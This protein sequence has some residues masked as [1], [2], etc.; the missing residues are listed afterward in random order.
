MLP[1]R[2]STEQIRQ[3]R[4]TNAIRAA[5][6]QELYKA[7]SKARI[8]APLRIETPEYWVTVRVLAITPRNRKCAL[9]TCQKMFKPTT[10][11][12]LYCPSPGR[13]C[14]NK[15]R[16]LKKVETKNNRKA[17]LAAEFALLRR[18][19]EFAPMPAE[20]APTTPMQQDQNCSRTL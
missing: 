19:L 20:F 1:K 18:N 14:L 7:L 5:S 12:Q 15:A 9:E 10:A 11:R 4:L 16:W 8:R 3:G 6:I 2:N 13:T 17:E